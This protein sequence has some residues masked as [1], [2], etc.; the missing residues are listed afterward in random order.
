MNAAR[1]WLVLEARLHRARAGREQVARGR[2]LAAGGW[3]QVDQELRRALAQRGACGR[4][5]S[6]DL[7]RSRSRADARVRDG[8][9]RAD[10]IADRGRQRDAGRGAAGGAA[11]TARFRER[12]Q[13][14]RAHG[15]PGQEAAQIVGQLARAGVA[16]P[17]VLLERRQADRLEVARHVRRDATR[18]EGSSVWMRT[19]TSAVPPPSNGRR[20][21]RSS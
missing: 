11:R 8:R 6:R 10:A 2:A 17:R 3:K 5:R 13:R 21:V 12:A 15:L 16:A 4:P 18:R 9:G 1:Q 14:P 19:S 20:S 7:A